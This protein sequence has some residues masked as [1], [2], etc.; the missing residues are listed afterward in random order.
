MKNNNTRPLS[1]FEELLQNVAAVIYLFDLTAHNYTWTNGKYFDILGYDG[2]ELKADAIECANSLC[3]PDDKTIMTE[4]IDFFKK[5]KGSVWSGVYRIK[6]KQGHWVWLFSKI[7]VLKR[8]KNGFPE[9]MIGLATDV[10]NMPNTE[11]QLDIL[12]KERMSLRN[13][14]KINT[15]TKRELEIAG[16][17]AKGLSYTRIAVMLNIHAETVNSHRKNIFRKLGLRNIAQLSC[18]ASENGL[19]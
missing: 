14:E 9:L 6:H 10:S 18:F 12:Y 16:L 5:D 17:I 19:V 2:E 11:K 3:H 15:L 7:S 4:R 1:F 8:D 13:S